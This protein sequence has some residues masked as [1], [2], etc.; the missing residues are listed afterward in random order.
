MD[1]R[2]RHGLEDN[3]LERVGH[4]GVYTSGGN[5][6]VHVYGG[7]KGVNGGIY[8]RVYQYGWYRV[9]WWILGLWWWLW[10]GYYDK[11]EE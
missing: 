2:G 3:G 7:W 6:P 1:N 8:R 4:I 11:E 5:K 9:W 10:Y